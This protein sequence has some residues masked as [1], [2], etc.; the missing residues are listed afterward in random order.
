M[1]RRPSADALISGQVGFPGVGDRYIGK[2]RADLGFL[3]LV[4]EL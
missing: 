4:I 3:L 2:P 1:S